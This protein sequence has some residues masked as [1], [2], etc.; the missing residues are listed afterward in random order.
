VHK[1]SIPL[2]SLAFLALAVATPL[3]CEEEK[4]PAAKTEPAPPSAGFFISVAHDACPDVR[5]AAP[6]VLAADY[7][8]R[9]APGVW[10]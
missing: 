7:K 8:V 5:L 10:R 6:G 1:T 9:A 4:S 2:R 3:L